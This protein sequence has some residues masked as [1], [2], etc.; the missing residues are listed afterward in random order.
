MFVNIPLRTLSISLVNAAV[1]SNAH[2]L[3]REERESD[4]TQKIVTY[5]YKSGFSCLRKFLWL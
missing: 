5:L 4:K 3:F 2:N 1:Q